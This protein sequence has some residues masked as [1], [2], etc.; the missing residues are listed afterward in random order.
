[1]SE[2]SV[3]CPVC[4]ARRKGRFFQRFDAA[5][6]TR[7]Y[8][9]FQCAPCG[10]IFIDPQ[11]LEA[12]DRGEPLIRYEDSYWSREISSA[13][14]RSFGAA[15]ARMAE[16]MYY[17]RIPVRKFLDIGTGS[18]YFL[19]AVAAYL[20]SHREMFYGVERFPPPE[21]LRS[22]SDRYFTAG[23]SAAGC[24]FD[25]GICMEV[26]EHLTPTMLRSLFAEVFQVSSPSALY[27]VNSGLAEFTMCEDRSYLDPFVRGHIVSYSIRGVRELLSG[28][29]V[30]VHSIRGKT[31]AFAV[32][33]APPSTDG[34]TEDISERIWSALPENLEILTDPGMGS[35]L[36][37][38]GLESARAYR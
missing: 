13:V 20:P 26:I 5:G 22:R 35:V 2:K 21:P 29:G 25:A 24:Q 28:L 10:S 23:Y 37:I 3:D 8:D 19:D 4:G 12:M 11:V 33:C 38:L 32:E 34:S 27:L 6:G 9:Y 16:A 18:G 7:R 1:M 36:R 30:T 14:E 15:L 31:W 17:V